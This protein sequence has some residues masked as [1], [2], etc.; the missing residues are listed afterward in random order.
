MPFAVSLRVKLTILILFLFL[1]PLS[2][3]ASYI[4]FNE[5]VNLKVGIGTSIT[6]NAGLTVMSGNVGIGTWVPAAALDVNG[7]SGVAGSTALVLHNGDSQLG[8]SLS[9]ITFGFEGSTNYP[10]WIHTRHNSG[11]YINNAIDFYTDD[12]TAAGVFPTNAI[13]GMS[14]SGGNV[15][16]GTLSPQKP[17][18]VMGDSY[19][20]GNI[21]IG[22]TLTTTSALSIMNGNVGIGTW[23][24]SNLFQVNG[25]NNKTYIQSNGYLNAAGGL[26]TNGITASN[27]NPGSLNIQSI[28]NGNIWILPSGTGNVGIGTQAPRAFLDVTG[29]SAT[30]AP[31]VFTS[32]GNLGIG[33]VTADGGQLIIRTGN[34]GIGSAWPGQVLDVAG[35]VRATSFIGNGSQLT[36]IGGMQWTITNTNDVYL[37]NNGNVGLGTTIT[38]AG[39]ALAVM[40]GNVGIGTWVPNGEFIVKAR[41]GNNSNIAFAIESNVSNNF[42]FQITDAGTPSFTTNLDMN[43]NTITRVPL[44]SNDQSAGITVSDGSGPVLLQPTSG[45]VGIGTST[46]LGGLAVMNGNVGIGTWVPNALFQVGAGSTA[47]TDPF[48]VTSAGVGAFSG[49]VTVNGNFTGA[50]IVSAGGQLVNNY[51]G[52]GYIGNEGNNASEIFFGGEYPTSHVTLQSVYNGTGNGDYINFVEGNVGIGTFEVMRMVNGNVGIGTTAP[53]G[54]EIENHNVGIGTA[55]TGGVGEGALTV[56]NGN[57]GIGTWVPNSNV[58]INGSLSVNY[59]NV[60]SN[61]TLNSTN[62]LVYVDTT[63]GVVT[64]TLPTAAG[65]GGRCYK[66]VDSGGQAATNNIT[67]ASNGGNISG[68][69]TQTMIDN[70]S[71]DDVCSNGTNWFIS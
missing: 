29:A 54:F 22:T 44:L 52:T 37:P 31:L 14:I 55:F 18:S 28:N 46:P 36:G 50:N 48:S 67:I 9:Q 53:T 10:Q 3:R 51:G 60:T 71:S 4:P 57:V 38:S 32:G 20:N 33:T 2:A 8:S 12:G 69:S 66:I 47:A 7:Y 6:S 40:N 25:T 11:T 56:M 23:V 17:F 19:L 63:G 21:G 42:L 65:I 61:T 16:V 59:V 5:N 62:Y 34:V 45:N 27:G 43:H 68:S 39:A 70:Y 35:T 30:T 58:S 1:L 49:A 41:D 24:P 15:G 26:Y 13:L 64:I